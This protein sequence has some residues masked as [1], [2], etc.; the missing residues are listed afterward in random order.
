MNLEIEKKKKFF[1]SLKKTFFACTFC[2]PN[3]NHVIIL[4]VFI[5]LILLL[6]ILTY[7]NMNVLYRIFNIILKSVFNL[8]SRIHL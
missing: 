8:L 6:Y 4:V 2:F 5:P 1:L 3:T 7:F